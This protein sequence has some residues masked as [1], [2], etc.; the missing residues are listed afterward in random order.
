MAK[1]YYLVLGVTPSA[2]EEEIRSAYRQQVKELHPDRY[3]G[4]SRPFL[5]VQE[6][7]AILSDLVRRRSYNRDT[8]GVRIQEF[9]GHPGPEPLRFRRPPAE[10]LR[11]SERP[12]DLGEVALTRSFHTYS[13]SFEEVFNRLSSNFSRL[14]HPKS[15]RIES[16]TL[17]IP[18]SAEHAARGGHARVMIPARAECPTCR[19][20]GRVGPYE[21]GR[22]AGEGGIAGEYPLCLAFPPGLATDYA[23]RIPLDRYGIR[24]YY[25]TVVFRISRTA[26]Q[27]F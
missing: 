6:A 26:S 25:V 1:N 7:Y 3:G 12:V 15:E 14:A 18:I 16:L 4:D 17:E 10:P 13:P 24:N 9:F 20:M 8:L 5:E 2:T 11:S 22:C 27:G 23:V 21:C 19:G